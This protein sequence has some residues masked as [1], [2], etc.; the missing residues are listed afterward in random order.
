[1]VFTMGGMLFVL[2]AGA[3]TAYFFLWD[4]TPYGRQ[5]QGFLG[6]PVPELTQYLT[7]NGFNHTCIGT[8]CTFELSVPKHRSH[9][10][11]MVSGSYEIMAADNSVGAVTT[12][13][14]CHADNDVNLK[15]GCKNR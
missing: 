2:G 11:K 15:L 1:M 3:F 9:T 6:E 13:E 4:K 10:A 12:S 14:F 5:L 7:S 8:I